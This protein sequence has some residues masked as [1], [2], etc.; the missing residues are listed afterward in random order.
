MLNR[1]RKLAAC[2]IAHQSTTLP[3]VPYFVWEIIIRVRRGRGWGLFNEP[4]SSGVES[5]SC[6]HWN[7]CWLG[8]LEGYEYL[9]A[10][11]PEGCVDLRDTM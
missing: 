3:R 5:G 2:S 8:L 1:T 9:R 4:W 7:M 10:R 6:T 11:G